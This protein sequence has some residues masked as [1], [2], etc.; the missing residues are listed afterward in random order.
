LKVFHGRPNQKLK[1]MENKNN[2]TIVFE[3]EYNAPAAVVWK[4]ITDK[5]QMKQW[6]FDIA[7]F[8]PEVGFKFQFSGQGNEGQKYLHLCEV[9]EVIPGKKLAYSWTYDGYPGYS[10]VSFELFAG[11]EKTKLKLTH[12][13]LESFAG[14]GPSFTIESFTGGWTMLIGTLL[15]EFVEK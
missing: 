8:R 12:T 14:L 9:T 13:G 1:K 15:K 7:A 5:D 10:L 2:N 3:K 4:A 6:Y 11:D